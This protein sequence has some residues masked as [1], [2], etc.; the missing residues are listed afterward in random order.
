MVTGDT[1]SYHHS[2][3]LWECNCNVYQCHNTVLLWYRYVL[4]CYVMWHSVMLT[5][6]YFVLEFWCRIMTI[7]IYHNLV[8]QCS[9]M[10]DLLQLSL[11][12]RR[13]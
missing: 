8:S 12:S 4:L 2:A 11:T 9:I 6:M 10:F 13:L 7:Q 5:N 3:V 1:V